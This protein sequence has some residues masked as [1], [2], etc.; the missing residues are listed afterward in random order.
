MNQKKEKNTLLQVYTQVGT[1][2]YTFMY[3]WLT[4]MYT[5]MYHVCS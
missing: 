5:Y 1:I 2:S 3:V 4:C